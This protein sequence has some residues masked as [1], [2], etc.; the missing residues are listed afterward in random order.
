[1]ENQKEIRRK[2]L[3][4]DSFTKVG[5]CSAACFLIVEIL[6][7]VDVPLTK[8]S[9]L[10]IITVLATLIT[11][12]RISAKLSPH[13]EGWEKFEI[14]EGIL[15]FFNVGQIIVTTL[16]INFGVTGYIQARVEKIPM[17]PVLESPSKKRGP[18]SVKDEPNDQL[19]KLYWLRD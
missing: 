16:V 7:L 17:N 5:S 19:K 14:W 8:V 13:D 6:I 12:A 2:F 15:A 11:L 18:A 3:T 4:M 10:T 1:M 9:V